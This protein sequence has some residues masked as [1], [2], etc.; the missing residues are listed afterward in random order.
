MTLALRAGISTCPNDTFA[1]AGL[2]EGEVRAPGIE[3]DFVLADVEELNRRFLAGE[4]DV[5]KVSFHAAL[6]A[7]DAALVL[8]SGAAL[9]RGVGPLLLAR[10]GREAGDRPRVLLPG[11]WTTAALLWELFH[12]G[13]GDVRHVV[14]SE[15]MPALRAGDADLGVCIHEG[16]FTWREQG[17]ALVE[18]L[19]ARWERAT[20]AELPLGGIAARRAL[21]RDV[22]RRVSAA[23]RSSVAWARAHEDRALAVARRHAQELAEPVLRAHVELYVN[24]RTLELGDEG[25]A[26]LAVLAERARAR[27]LVAGG[28]ALEVA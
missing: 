11:R 7:A 2:L 8:E 1:F 20:G 26:A 14:F 18:D 22:A 24:E 19:G 15:I 25:R 16:R 21:G 23:I 3:L 5:A 9:G 17:L 6:A 12:G 10:P 27:E 4:L 13:E 28:G